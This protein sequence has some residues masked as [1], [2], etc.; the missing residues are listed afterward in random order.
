VLIAST[1][2][3]IVT[4][5]RDKLLR[6]LFLLAMAGTVL[7]IALAAY[8]GERVSGGIRLLTEAAQ[9]IQGGD[10]SRPANVKAEDEVGVLGSA[11]DL[12]T[13]S[14]SEQ[15]RA[16]QLAAE[17]ETALRS[18]LEAVVAG[19][20]EALIAVDAEGQITLFN[21]AAE[22][23]LGLRIEDAI[24]ELAADVLDAEAEDGSDIDTRLQRPTPSRWSTTATVSTQLG[25]RIPVAISSGPLRNLEGAASGAVLVLRDLRPEREVERIKSE[26]LSRIG[27]ELRTPLTG[28]LGYAEI[29]LR[30]NVPEQR[31]RDMHQQIVDAGR[32][33][34]R[35][36]Q[37][38]EF[39]AAAEAGRSLLRSEPISVRE[40][41]DEVVEGWGSRVNGTHT[42]ERRAAR[43][44]PAIRGDRRWL[45]MAIDELIDNAVKFSPDGGQVLV[46]VAPDKAGVRVSVA[47]RGVGLTAREKR[48]VFVDFFQGDASD[49]R[50]FGGLGLGLSLV[51]RVAEAHGGRVEVE[52]VPQKG[53]KFSMIIPALPND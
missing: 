45:T 35:V 17:E 6:E 38:L 3:T 42:V 25:P 39:S 1:P 46:T 22:E 19:M 28:I 12:M 44:I 53:S 50:R 5:A 26:F 14:I 16:L 43:R 37:M 20:G 48:D 24:G 32:R 40:V 51:K 29:L 21:R 2:D 9:R 49:T 8:A 36:V 11:F 4:D 31:A 13:A 52:S 30:R 47:D 18:Q 10:F 34:Y 7:A 41:V 33:L 27:H 23:L 15:T